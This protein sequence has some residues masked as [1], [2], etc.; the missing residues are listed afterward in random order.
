MDEA[1]IWKEGKLDLS[2]SGNQEFQGLLSLKSPLSVQY[3]GQ[4]KD[5]VYCILV[6][7]IHIVIIYHYPR[8]GLPLND[9][10]RPQGT[11]S[12]WECCPWVRLQPHPCRMD[13]FE[14]SKAFQT[15]SIVPKLPTM[16]HLHN[17]GKPAF[18]KWKEPKNPR[19]KHNKFR[20]ATKCFR[21]VGKYFRAVNNFPGEHQNFSGD[22]KMFAGTT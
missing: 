20:G 10:Y 3:S 4:A 9:R 11:Y 18:P 19:L 15:P 13:E 14:D 6:M 12:S 16:D 17:Q 1:T 5:L 8:K 2:F 21:E 7:C 22:T